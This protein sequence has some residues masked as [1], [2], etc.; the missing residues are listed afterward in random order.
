MFF[1][2]I[3]VVEYRNRLAAPRFGIL[4]RTSLIDFNFAGRFSGTRWWPNTILYFGSHSHESLLHIAG[5]LGRCFEEWNAQIVGVFLHENNKKD[6][7]FQI[8]T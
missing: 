1:L 3:H 6:R 5:I 8:R 2:I 4:N 7:S